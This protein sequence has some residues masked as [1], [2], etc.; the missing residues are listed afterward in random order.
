MEVALIS[1]EIG[2]R[3]RTLESEFRHTLRGANEI[4]DLL[5]QFCKEGLWCI[6]LFCS[7]LDAM[8]SPLL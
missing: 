6:S 1:S 7:L 5:A 2:E 8:F 4:A 3:C